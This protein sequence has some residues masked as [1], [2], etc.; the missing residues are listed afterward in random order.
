M[1]IYPITGTVAIISS[2]LVSLYLSLSMEL[3]YVNI[4]IFFF[5]SQLIASVG[6]ELD[7]DYPFYGSISILS[8]IFVAYILELGTLGIIPILIMYLGS[9]AGAYNTE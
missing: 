7:P 8:G 4:L 2:F 5:V 1:N 3:A 9:Q 6:E